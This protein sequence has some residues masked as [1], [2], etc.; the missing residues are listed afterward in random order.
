MNNLSTHITIDPAVCKGKPTIRGMR[1]TVAQML[2]LVAAEMSFEEIL[3][4]SPYLERDDIAACL[5]YAAL[6]MSHK[7][8]G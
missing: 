2:E 4:D 5:Q 8:I 1:F 3:A 6:M 7:E